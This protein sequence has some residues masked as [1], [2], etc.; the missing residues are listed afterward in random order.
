MKME[1][2]WQSVS[3]VLDSLFF[4]IISPVF[5]LLGQGLELVLLKPLQLMQLPPS[6]QVFW[7]GIVAAALS[8]L[9][10]KLM[11]VE[12]KD[13]AFRKAFLAKK[14][15]QDDLHLISD[16]KSREKFAKAIDDDIDEDF[17]G[18]L[19]GRFARYGIIYLLPIF[20]TLYWL[21]STVQEG[22]FLIVFPGEPYGIRG[23]SL[24]FIFLFSYC[25]SLFVY[26]KLRKKALRKKENVTL[27]GKDL[28]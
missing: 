25:L 20:L 9:L 11:R 27:A 13:A 26:F 7:V 21:N 22:P 5:I 15:Q 16:W 14:A 28:C 10:R 24:N 12:E 8:I 23:I 17:N 6:L 4:G 1:N 18:Y 19:A 3:A 2:I